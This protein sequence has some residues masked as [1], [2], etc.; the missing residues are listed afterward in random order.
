MSRMHFS[1]FLKDLQTI[2]PRF[3]AATSSLNEM[4][5]YLDRTAHQPASFGANK[6]EAV[7]V[8]LK[9]CK[10]P[11]DPKI[12]KYKPALERLLQVWGQGHRPY[13]LEE[14]LQKVD[15]KRVCF[16]GDSR[17]PEIIF[18]NGFTKLN[19][20]EQATYREYKTHE[21]HKENYVSHPMHGMSKAGDLKP[22][23]GVCVTPSLNVATLFPLPDKP[24][25]VGK[26]IFVYVVY[27]SSGY[28]TNLRQ[29]MDFLTGISEIQ[30]IVDTGKG[31]KRRYD[32]VL[33]TNLVD[34]IDYDIAGAREARVRNVA[35]NLYGLE[36]A[37]DSVDRSLVFAALKITRTW[38][39]INKGKPDYKDGGTYRVDQVIRNPR[40]RYPAGFESVVEVFLEKT[41][42]KSGVMSVTADGFHQSLMV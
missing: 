11:N 5:M 38:N 28:N 16:R 32:K 36:M 25:E 35:Q 9:F 2:N 30:N 26:P 21:V 13:P 6:I 19:V 41:N 18:S 34:E 7:R 33:D 8:A 20:N 27:L 42:N 22:S 31:T 29:A 12:N 24:E 14:R 23:S 39:T 17:P 3:K 4:I 15:I 1:A 37:A 40:A 10:N